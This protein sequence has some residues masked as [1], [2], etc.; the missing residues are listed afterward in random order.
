MSSLHR[1][2]HEQ[3]TSISPSR[4]LVLNEQKRAGEERL[5]WEHSLIERDGTFLVDVELTSS[6]GTRRSAIP[7]QMPSS[8]RLPQSFEPYE[9]GPGWRRIYVRDFK[10]PLSGFSPFMADSR[11]L[12]GLEIPEDR[13]A[14][15]IVTAHAQGH[16]IVCTSLSLLRAIAIPTERLAHRLLN[17]LS[18]DFLLRWA[19]NPLKELELIGT[20]PNA[21][22]VPFT[23]GEAACMAF[24]LRNRRL[25]SLWRSLKGL[26]ETG[27]TLSLPDR[28]EEVN[29]M[30]DAYANDDIVVIQRLRIC[31]ASFWPGD[32]QLIT[33]KNQKL[34]AYRWVYRRDNQ[35]VLKIA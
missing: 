27:W 3:L 14:N 13:G 7:H 11:R 17:P 32:W 33:I 22:R 20:H 19:A 15:E 21:G 6:A 30:F 23:A 5:V 16:Q 29:L 31:S 25:A 12:Q 9:L 2:I 10:V 28:P 35:L 18:V 24:W 34:D 4:H 8:W 26:G 1:P